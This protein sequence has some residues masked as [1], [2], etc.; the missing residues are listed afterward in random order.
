MILVRVNNSQEYARLMR[1]YEKKG[2]VWA[3]GKK[4]FDYT[5]MSDRQQQLK[6]RGDFV[7][8][9]F[10]DWFCIGGSDWKEQSCYKRVGGRRLLLSVGEAITRLGLD[11]IEKEIKKDLKNKERT[12]ELGKEKIQLVYCETEKEY[13][14]LMKE[15]EKFGFKWHDGQSPT[16]YNPFCGAFYP[17]YIEIRDKFRCA[18]L[19][20]GWKKDTGYKT[21]EVYNVAE[22]IE[23][24]KKAIPVSRNRS[25]VLYGETMQLVKIQSKEDLNAYLKR[26]EDFGLVW[27]SEEKPTFGR[28]YEVM[29]G[30]YP[31][32]I[33]LTNRFTSGDESDYSTDIGYKTR[34]VYTVQEAIKMM[35][36]WDKDQLSTC[37][38]S[39]ARKDCVETVDQNTFMSKLEDEILG[40]V[41]KHFKDYTIG[42]NK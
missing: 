11:E 40:V 33:R 28:S 26:A 3:D 37:R 31:F 30:K 27:A 14:S 42:K 21:R 2:W 35:D 1:A 8:I 13:N 29:R 6:T 9:D 5:P 10:K 41:R 39:C 38:G 25:M 12:H 7:V 34:G 36:N 20:V 22:A 32:V 23:M 17:L 19:V 16:K 4:P 18:D 15:M 24:L